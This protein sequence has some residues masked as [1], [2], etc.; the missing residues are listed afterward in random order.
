MPVPWP[1]VLGATVAPG[2]HPFAR[3]EGPCFLTLV[4]R[5]SCDLLDF[6]DHFLYMCFVVKAK[7]ISSSMMVSNLSIVE[8]KR[9]FFAINVHFK[10]RT[11]PQSKRFADFVDTLMLGF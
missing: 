1:C 5:S 10:A 3:V 4:N 7:G 6:V 9:F 2:P 8:P 11:G